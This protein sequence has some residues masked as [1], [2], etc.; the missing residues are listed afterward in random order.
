MRL[1]RLPLPVFLV[2]DFRQVGYANT[3]IRP[4]IEVYGQ[5]PLDNVDG[6][7]VLYNGERGP[8]ELQRP[9]VL[10]QDGSVDLS[11]ARSVGEGFLGA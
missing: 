1:G 10:R 7:D 3:W 9:G 8:G 5:V 11:A 4:P 6:L 2:S